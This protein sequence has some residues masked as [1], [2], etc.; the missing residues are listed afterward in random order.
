[1][2]LVFEVVNLTTTPNK[3]HNELTEKMLLQDLSEHL[4]CVL[5]GLQMD[6]EFVQSAIDTLTLDKTLHEPQLIATVA[7]IAVQLLYKDL[8]IDHPLIVELLDALLRGVPFDAITQL[9]PLQYL[10]TALQSSDPNI[11]SLSL[12]VLMRA[13]PVDIIANTEIIPLCVKLL[14]DPNTSMS[15]VSQI[16]KAMDVLLQGELI[17]RRV[18]SA[19]VVEMLR[20]MKDDVLLLLRLHDLVS[21]LLP[22]I[23]PGE[24]PRDLYQLSEWKDDPLWVVSVLQFYTKVLET[25]KGWTIEDIRPSVMLIGKSYDR[26]DGLGYFLTF[27][28]KLSYAS[29]ELFK[30]LDSMYL[31]LSPKDTDL[32]S[33]VNPEYLLSMHLQIVKSLSPLSETNV[34]IYAN[35]ISSLGSF[36]LV[37][38]QLK[39]T[40]LSRVSYLKFVNFVFVLTR[41]DHSTKFLLLELPSVMNRLLT[42]KNEIVETETFTTRKLC[43]EQLISQGDFLGVWHQKLF[44]EWDKVTKGNHLM[45][46]VGILDDTL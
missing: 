17:R 27:C 23:R 40:Y 39:S 14:C 44:S 24:L 43:L 3:L 2:F 45:P 20:T 19:Q 7:Q 6:D 13:K 16:D 12:K 35:L 41:Y 33:V 26:E 21:K 18:L 38:N 46:G 25:A 29:F 31:H 36:N 15:V 37:Q 11:Q 9:F 42:P 1:M 8:D 34:D 32:L 28:S 5:N 4:T 30:E 10:V 22:L